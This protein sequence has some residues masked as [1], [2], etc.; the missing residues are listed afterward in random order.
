MIFRLN[1]RKVTEIVNRMLTYQLLVE[2][3]NRFLLEG[4]SLVIS[5]CLEPV[6]VKDLQW[7][8]LI[9]PWTSLLVPYVD[10]LASFGLIIITLLL[11]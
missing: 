1:V 7:H 6:I 3:D 2:A 10:L 11:R 4:V 9:I 8:L 5:G